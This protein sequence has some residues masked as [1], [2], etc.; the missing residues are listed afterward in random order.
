M[1]GLPEEVIEDLANRAREAERLLQRQRLAAKD[2]KPPTIR[3]RVASQPTFVRYVFDLP[4]GA[5]V[6]PDRHD[7]RLTLNFDR[8]IKWDLADV[9]ATLPPTL[10]SVDTDIDYRVGGHQFRSQRHAESAHLPRGQQYR[11]RYRPR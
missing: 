6:V 7:D 4:N 10:K 11:G 1:P 8:P 9:V 2:R 5:N 3:V